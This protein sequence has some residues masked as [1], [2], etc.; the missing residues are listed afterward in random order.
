MC[1]VRFSF[2]FKQKTAYEITYGDWSSDVCSSDLVKGVS[3]PPTLPPLPPPPPPP[4]LHPVR[5]AQR[6]PA[7]MAVNALLMISSSREKSYRLFF[8]GGT[9]QS[10]R[11]DP[12]VGA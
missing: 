1:A 2:F 4:P 8:K 6:I 9:P 3:P 11:S 12:K 7:A 10:A 5:P